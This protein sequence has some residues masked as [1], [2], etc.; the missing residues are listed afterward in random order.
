MEVDLTG[1]DDPDTAPHTSCNYPLCKFSE[2]SPAKLR[3]CIVAGCKN[4]HHHLCAINAG[5]EGLSS[6]CF[7]CFMEQNPLDVPPPWGEGEGAGEGECAGEGAGEGE[8]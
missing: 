8:G 3:L 2:N 6:H 4:W 7:T 1:D 5:D